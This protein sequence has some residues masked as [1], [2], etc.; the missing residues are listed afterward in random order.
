MVAVTYGKQNST[1]KWGGI[2]IAVAE[3]ASC[4]SL[5]RAGS[6]FPQRV[7]LN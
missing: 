5:K 4:I 1:I 6:Q 2:I 7:M 3:I